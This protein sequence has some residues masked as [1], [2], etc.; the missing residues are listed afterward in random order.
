MT[1]QWL[2][3]LSLATMLLPASCSVKERRENCPCWLEIAV[4][5]CRSVSRNVTVSAWN[6]GMV[7]SEAI[8]IFDYP[9]CYER[10]VPKGYVTVTAFAGRR[11][12]ELSGESLII[13]DGIPCDSLYARHALVDCTGE[14]ARDSVVLHKQFATVYLKI[15]RLQDEYPYPYRLVLRSAFDG[16]RLTDCSPHAGP[17]TLPLEALPDG[18][19]R[20]RVPRQGDGSL[21]IDLVLGNETVDSYPIG[22]HILRAGYSWLSEDLEDIY[23]GMDYGGSDPHITIEPWGDS[24]GY[25]SVI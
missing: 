20:F 10:T 23:I 12:Q 15:D 8:D 22:E 4:S 3:A 17:W 2:Y 13:P 7:F 9:D 5:G 6:P 24:P 21:S 19:F 11:A 18:T 14:F 25:D 1:R 16:L